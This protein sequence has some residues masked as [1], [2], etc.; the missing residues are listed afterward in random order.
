MNDMSK[1][2]PLSDE[3]KR[4]IS[5]KLKVRKITWAHKIAISNTG[6]VQPYEQRMKK[7]MFGPRNPAWKGGITGW[8]HK[9]RTSWEYQ[10]WRKAVLERDSRKCIWCG[11]TERLHADH[12]KPFSLFPELRFAIDNGRTLCQKCHFTTFNFKKLHQ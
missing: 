8:Q 5:K 7:R 6:K 4:K 11:S 12:I 9:I 1:R 10:L 3:T 2:K